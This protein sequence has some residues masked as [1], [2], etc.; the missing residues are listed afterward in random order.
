MIAQILIPSSQWLFFKIYTGTK[1][2][3]KVLREI[4]KPYTDTLIKKKIIEQCFFIRYNDPNF[5]IRLRLNISG[6]NSF[7][8]IF[9]YFNKYFSESVNNGLIWN[10]QLDTYKREIERYGSV[11]MESCESYFAIDSQSVIE[12]IDAIYDYP[13]SD[14]LRWLS[15]LVMLDDMLDMFCSSIE[16]KKAQIKIISDSFCKE[17]GIDSSKYFKPLKTKYRENKKEIEVFLKHEFDDKEIFNVLDRRKLALKPIASKIMENSIKYTDVPVMSIL[18]SLIH[19]TMNRLFRAN[20][21]LCETVEYSLLAEY[22]T[23]VIARSKK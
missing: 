23:S 4:I 17:H 18:Q 12:L 9:Q 21:R 11:T 1:S 5:H 8:E 14:E 6:V 22:Y 15:G 7:N 10:I 13:N 20:N 19:M 2:A 16:E 3:D